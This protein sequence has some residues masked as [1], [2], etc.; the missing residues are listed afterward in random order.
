MPGGDIEA[1]AQAFVAYAGDPAR[2]L[3]EG[4]AARERVLAGFD[5]RAQARRIQDE[6]VRASGLLNPG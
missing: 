6:I 4:A 2:R 1:L 5:S 3:R